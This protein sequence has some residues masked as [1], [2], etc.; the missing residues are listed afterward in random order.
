MSFII[1]II[2]YLVI[3]VL[4]SHNIFETEKI[5]FKVSFTAQENF[6]QNQ[7]VDSKNLT[8]DDYKKIGLSFSEIARN[9]NMKVQTCSEY[10]T[11]E[12]YGF[13]VSDCVSREL[14][15]KI[16]GKNYPVWKG[17][18]NKYCHCANMVDIGAYNTCSHYCKYCYANYDEDKIKDHVKNHRIDSTMLIGYLKDDDEIKVRKN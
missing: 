10:N 1:S 13:I 17:R 6:I 11:L 9:H 5:E 8:N 2:L 18:N 15:K 3:N 16:T 7:T 4:F 14:A 12:E